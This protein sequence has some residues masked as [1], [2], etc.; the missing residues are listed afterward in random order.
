MDVF[1]LEYNP[2]ETLTKKKISGYDKKELE[3]DIL[4]KNITDAGIQLLKDT[5]TV[6]TY[7]NPKSE[8]ESDSEPD[9]CPSCGGMIEYVYTCGGCDK[10]MCD[11]CYMTV[12]NYCNSCDNPQCNGCLSI[13]DCDHNICDDCTEY[14]CC[15]KYCK[16]GGTDCS[17]GFWKCED[18]DEYTC[19]ECCKF[20]NYCVNYTRC[21]NCYGECELCRNT[22]EEILLKY[23]DKK[24]TKRRMKKIK[25]GVTSF[26]KEVLEKILSKVCSADTITL[27]IDELG[28]NWEFFQDD[29]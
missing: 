10:K 1:V 29:I 25:N 19:D 21:A 24:Q 5:G 22:L 13:A 9:V 20:C 16:Y 11:H 26:K 3:Q 28:K 2:K 14:A 6:N 18:C 7:H 4:G 8:S 27:I 15:G 12:W 23:L 17:F